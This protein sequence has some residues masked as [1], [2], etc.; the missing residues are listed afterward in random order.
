MLAW[1]FIT[2]CCN[3]YTEKIT[4]S[5]LSEQNFSASLDGQLSPISLS[6]TAFLLVFSAM[7][8]IQSFAPGDRGIR[9]INV[10]K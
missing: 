9:R 1:L 10:N 4:C 2:C 8:H 6:P 3:M 5:T 7:P